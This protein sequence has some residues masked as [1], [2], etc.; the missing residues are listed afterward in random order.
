MTYGESG[1][2][3]DVEDATFKKDVLARR[4]KQVSLIGASDVKF[5]LNDKD[6]KA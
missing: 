3:S 6:E 1:F 2:A 4:R 5:V